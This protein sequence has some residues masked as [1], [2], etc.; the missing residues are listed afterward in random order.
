MS[1]GFTSQQ[2]NEKCEQRIHTKLLPD[3]ILAQAFPKKLLDMKGDTIQPFFEKENKILNPNL[4][5]KRD[6]SK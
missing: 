2:I 5:S 3:S 1:T 6:L 4:F